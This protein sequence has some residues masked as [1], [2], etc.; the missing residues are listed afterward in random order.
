MGDRANVVVVQHGGKKGARTGG[1]FLYTHWGG[2]ELGRTLRDAL[3]R[4]GGKGRAATEGN[5]WDDEPYLVRI[6]FSEMLFGRD[7]A[8]SHE[9]LAGLTG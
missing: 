8:A 4:A 2:S 7:A 1:V 9:N 6:I 5:R 3:A